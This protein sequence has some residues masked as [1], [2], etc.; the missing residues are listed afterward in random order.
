MTAEADI[1]TEIRGKI[2][3]N[4]KINDAITIAS[5]GG[6]YSPWVLGAYF[7][8]KELDIYVLLETSGKTMAN[9]IKNK[10]IAVLISKNDAMQDF[11]QGT[12]EV[13]ILDDSEEPEVRKLILE[14]MPWFQTFTPVKPVKIKI[15]KYFISSLQS[16]WFPAKVFEA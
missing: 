3:E 7:A 10:D 12:G 11:I 13:E 14:K 4:F 5:T 15:R 9:L 2:L 8:S 16:G 1:Q 6:E